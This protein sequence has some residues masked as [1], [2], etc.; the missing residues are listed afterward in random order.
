M[1]REL[2]GLATG[3]DVYRWERGKHMPR[4]DTLEAVAKLFGIEVA[5]LYA[6]VPQEKA[7]ADLSDALSEAEPASPAKVEEMLREVLDQQAELLARVSEVRTFQEDLKPLLGHLERGRE[8]KR[9]GSS[10]S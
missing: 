9:R 7:D 3:N 10:S 1:A 8:G 5:D 4:L 2:T 6:G